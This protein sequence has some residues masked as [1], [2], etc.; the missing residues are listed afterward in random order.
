MYSFF[1]ENTGMQC[2]DNNCQWR[3]EHFRT[4]CDW[5]GCRSK[6]EIRK[7]IRSPA[8]NKTHKHNLQAV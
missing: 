8:P 1:S 7:R 3:V 4:N 5:H 2:L 6:N